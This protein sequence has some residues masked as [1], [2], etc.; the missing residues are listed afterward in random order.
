MP[1]QLE[2]SVTF[3]SSHP[4]FNSGSEHVC[5]VMIAGEEDVA[6]SEEFDLE[7][8]DDNEN[9]TS[10]SNLGRIGAFLRHDTFGPGFIGH[11]H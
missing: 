4:F 9:P 6:K 7:S 10:S 2:P 3:I 11:C 8:I 5:N 1:D